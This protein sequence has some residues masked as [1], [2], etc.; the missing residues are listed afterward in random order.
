MGRGV[1]AAFTGGVKKERGQ[2]F[3]S[4]EKKQKTFVHSGVRQPGHVCQVQT[5]FGSFFQKRP[6]FPLR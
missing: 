5:F 3:F 1:K 2:I 4:E 6:Y